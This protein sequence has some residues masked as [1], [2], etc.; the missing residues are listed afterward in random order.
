M[1]I[2]RLKYLSWNADTEDIRNFFQGLLIPKGGVQIIGGDE[3]EA[4]IG[5]YFLNNFHIILYSVAIFSNFWVNISLFSYF[6]IGILFALTI[7][8]FF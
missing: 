3:G 4:F 7:S 8:F 5:I 6:L 2:L 1:I